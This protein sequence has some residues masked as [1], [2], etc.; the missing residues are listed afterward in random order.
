MPSI[1]HAGEI[2]LPLDFVWDYVS[3]LSHV[4]EWVFGITRLE[5][6]G[7]QTRGVGAAWA[8]TFHVAPVTLRATAEMVEWVERE[9]VTAHLSKG[10]TAEITFAFEELADSHVRLACEVDYLLPAGVAGRA[11]GKVLDPIIN[12]CVRR[13]EV[14]LRERLYA[15][16]ELQTD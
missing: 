10:F 14:L 3:D 8:G 4:P 9:R 11:L 12:L 5:P 7:E 13:A 1:Q 16:A 15:V 6:V 2:H